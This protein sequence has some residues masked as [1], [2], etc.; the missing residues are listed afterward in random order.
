L[1]DYDVTQGESGLESDVIEWG[2]PEEN[3]HSIDEEPIRRLITCISREKVCLLNSTTR[4]KVE[5]VHFLGLISQV[6]P[7]SHKH[8]VGCPLPG[9]LS[10]VFFVP[11]FIEAQ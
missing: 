10:V 6:A 4:D 9:Y 7:G 2:G 3:P 5:K 11:F 1:A 8:L